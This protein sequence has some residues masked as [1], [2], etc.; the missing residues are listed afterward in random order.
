MIAFDLCCDRG[1]AFEAWFKDSA[2]FSRQSKRKLLS[3]AVCGS[4]KVMKAVSA[5]ALSGTRSQNESKGPQPYAAHPEAQ[6]MAALMGELAELRKKVEESA[7]NVG[8]R[9]AD[10]A[11]KIHYGEVEKRSIYG[12]ATDEQA[13]RLVDEG[14][15]F[16]RIPWVRRADS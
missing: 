12:E 16:A 2:E 9:F 15:E 10:E 4:P 5:P 1:H 13:T 8:D 7:D 11:L 6:K 14:V 3:C